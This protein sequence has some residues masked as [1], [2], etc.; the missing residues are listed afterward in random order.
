MYAKTKKIYALEFSMVKILCSLKTIRIRNGANS[1]LT[2]IFLLLLGAAKFLVFN[3]Y[4]DTQSRASI[5]L[6]HAINCHRHT[7][8]TPREKSL[9]KYF[10]NYFSKAMNYLN[11]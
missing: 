8:R 10:M 11:Y 5:S 3:Q 6:T 2:S 4:T 1:E 9:Q 7:R